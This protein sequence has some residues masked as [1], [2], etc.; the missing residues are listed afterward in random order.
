MRSAGAS[1]SVSPAG[2]PF[3]RARN[4]FVSPRPGAVARFEANTRRRPS[5]ETCGKPSKPGAYVMRRRSVPFGR[6]AHRSNSRALLCPWLLENRMTSP[7]GWKKGANEA[8][9]RYV[10]CIACVPSALAIQISSFEG[11]TRPCARRAL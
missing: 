4:R 11:R 3:Q 10:S 6:T 7:A 1:A 2:S 8:A 9:S 5:G